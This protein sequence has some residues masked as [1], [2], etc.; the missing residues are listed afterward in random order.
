CS[1]RPFYHNPQDLK[2]VLSTPELA[3]AGD[4]SEE[5]EP[6]GTAC[7][8]VAEVLAEEEGVEILAMAATE[9]EAEV[10]ARAAVDR[11]TELAEEDLAVWAASPG[12]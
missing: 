3:G 10:S 4:W 5:E 7:P 11:I 2:Q 12:T 1:C 6:C 9:P 8:P